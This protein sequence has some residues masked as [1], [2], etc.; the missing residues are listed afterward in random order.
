M[1]NLLYTWKTRLWN[2]FVSC[3]K[4]KYSKLF[5]ILPSSQWMKF[6]GF[7]SWSLNHVKSLFIYAKIF[8]LK[9]AE[10]LCSIFVKNL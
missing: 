7:F 5:T 9:L 10:W 6:H 1:K 2:T 4:L 8:S 3:M